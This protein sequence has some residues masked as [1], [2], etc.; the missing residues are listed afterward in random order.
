MQLWDLYRLRETSRMRN[1]T[2]FNFSSI[3]E[4]GF[5]PEEECP[6]ALTWPRFCRKSKTI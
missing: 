4:L 2:L 3:G 1:V 6:M 5:K